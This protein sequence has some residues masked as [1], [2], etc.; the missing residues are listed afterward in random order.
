MITEMAILT[1]QLDRE[2]LQSYYKDMVNEVGEIFE[3]FIDE[4][5]A[6][7][8]NV[9]VAFAEKNYKEA[10]ESLHKIAPSFYN[11]GLPHLTKIVQ[12]V[13]VHVRAGSYDIA[14]KEMDAFEI[15]LEEYMPAIL[16]ESQRLADL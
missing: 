15:E 7:M 16:E 14:Q 5:P 13:E 1:K 2:F 8:N 6:D 9:K 12:S 10:A 11:I 3:L 4:M